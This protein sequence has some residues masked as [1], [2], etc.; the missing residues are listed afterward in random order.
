MWSL[1]GVPGGR[2][3]VSRI[4][5]PRHRHQECEPFYIKA[6]RRPT[7]GSRPPPM[8]GKSAFGSRAREE[9]QDDGLQTQHSGSDMLDLCVGEY[10]P[11]YIY[12]AL[13]FFIQKSTALGD[14]GSVDMLECD[15]IRQLRQVSSE[16]HPSLAQAQAF[17]FIA[18]CLGSYTRLQIRLSQPQSHL[19]LLFA[20]PQPLTCPNLH[21]CRPRCRSST[22][23]R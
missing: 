3:D 8:R 19:C 16:L 17:T 23:P 9:A 15:V 4:M 14:H 10:L 7:R 13:C 18:T 22:P 12:Q 2:F 6:V 21:T 11:E 1:S 20:A 5:L